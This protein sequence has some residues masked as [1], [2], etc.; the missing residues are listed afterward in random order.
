MF[1]FLWKDREA[2]VRRGISKTALLTAASPVRDL[3][4]SGSAETSGYRATGPF[5]IRTEIETSILT[6]RGWTGEWS[7]YERRAETAMRLLIRF[8][9]II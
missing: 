2:Y 7:T 3:Q 6:W 4:S 9:S 1:R 5:R 8:V